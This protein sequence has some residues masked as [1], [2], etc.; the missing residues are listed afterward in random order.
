MAGRRPPG[1]IC[2][3]LMLTSSPAA[4]PVRN[5]WV[6][7]FL[8]TA[9]ALCQQNFGKGFHWCDKPLVSDAL[10]NRKEWMNKE[11]K[12]CTNM[13]K[14]HAIAGSTKN[15]C[16]GKSKLNHLTTRKSAEYLKAITPRTYCR[17]ML[18]L[19]SLQIW[20]NSSIHFFKW[21][22]N[23]YIWLSKAVAARR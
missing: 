12:H 3:Q 23:L 17:S 4:R 19:R 9:C 2:S 5:K 1:N 11:K 22:A 8:S 15:T 6:T 21:S 18:N 20:K 10:G 14:Q 13:H 16:L 7:M